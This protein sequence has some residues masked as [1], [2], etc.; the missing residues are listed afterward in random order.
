MDNKVEQALRIESVFWVVIGALLI[1]NCFND[2]GN[3]VYVIGPCGAIYILL[4]FSVMT[5]AIIKENK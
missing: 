1:I 4:A 2:I 3:W 5:K